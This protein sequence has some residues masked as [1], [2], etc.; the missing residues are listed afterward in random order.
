MSDDAAREEPSPTNPAEVSSASAASWK[1]RVAT[2]GAGLS[3]HWFV[4]LITV[5]L[6]AHAAALWVFAY[7]RT[8]ERPAPSG[9]VDLGRFEFR[10][11]AAGTDDVNAAAFSLHIR[12]LDEVEPRARRE[13]A[14][15]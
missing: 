2:L 4:G 10:N 14:D 7:E 13:L 11:V 12:F 3:R 5:A 6:L 1:S 9:E 15:H 8:A